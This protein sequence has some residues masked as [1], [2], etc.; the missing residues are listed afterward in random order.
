M[1][2]ALA[3]IVGSVV[4][5]MAAFLIASITKKYEDRKHLRELIINTAYKEWEYTANY[6][7][8]TPSGGHQ[9]PLTDYI[10]VMSKYADMALDKN[11]TS[12]NIESKLEE[13]GNIDMKIRAYREKQMKELKKLYEDFPNNDI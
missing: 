9:L 1:I 12:E 8:S 3:A 7:R 6:L 13:I 5:A 11:L 4:S 10:I 2:V